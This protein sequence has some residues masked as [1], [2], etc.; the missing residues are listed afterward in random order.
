MLRIYKT[1]EYYLSFHFFSLFFRR[2]DKMARQVWLVCGVLR[3]APLYLDLFVGVVVQSAEPFFCLLSGRRS[4][5][6]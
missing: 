5:K 1:E 6:K 4:W 3:N 2:I